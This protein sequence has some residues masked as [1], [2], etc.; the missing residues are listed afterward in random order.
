[1]VTAVLLE[2]TLFARL[3]DAVDDLLTAG[4]GDLIQF[5]LQAVVGLLGQ[6]GS[7]IGVAHGR[8]SPSNCSS[9]A[10]RYATEGLPVLPRA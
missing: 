2:V 7:A 6:P 9:A 8:V 10:I 5:L 4:S 3:L 1:M